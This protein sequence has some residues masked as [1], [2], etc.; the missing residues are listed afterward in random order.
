[1]DVRRALEIEPGSAAAWNSLGLILHLTGREEAAL[2][3]FTRACD[4]DARFGEAWMNRGFILQVLG[5]QIDAIPCFERAIEGGL[6]TPQVRFFLGNAFAAEGRHHEA[7]REFDLAV[8]AATGFA[9]AWNNRGSSL[10]QIS[11]FPE[12]AE[13]YARALALKERIVADLERK[14]GREAAANAL[15]AELAIALQAQ[16]RWRDAVACAGKSR[17]PALRFIASLLMPV[18]F[19]S[20]GMVV[21]ALEHLGTSV[22][23]LCEP[24]LRLDD[25][26]RQVGITAFHLPYFGT[27]ERPYQEAIARAYLHAVPGIETVPDPPSGAGRPRLGVLSGLLRNHSVYSMFGGLIERLDP[28]RFEVVFLQTAPGD[29]FTERIAA[30]AARHVRL[31]AN[32]EQARRQ[33]LA[34]RLDVL[35]YPEVGGD[36]LSYFLGFSRLAPVQCVTW[37]HPQTTGSPAMDYFISS[38]HLEREDGDREYS[39]KLVRMPHLNAW[40]SPPPPPPPRSPGQLG[41]PE[42]C[43]LYAYLQIANKLHPD[44]DRVLNEILTRDP[45][46]LLVLSE[47]LRPSFKAILARR[48]ETTAPRLLD[49]TVWLP[50]MPLDR[51]LRVLQL[52]DALLAPI[53]FGGGRS[54]FDALSAGVPVVT[55]RGPFL[56]SRITHAIY[57]EAGI[58][59]LTAESDEQYIELALRLARD[60]KWREQMRS[61]VR[62]KAPACFES[63]AAVRDLNEFFASIAPGA[64]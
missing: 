54:T 4:C 14:P 21:E 52:T 55:F 62:T 58:E 63:E 51:Y 6:A 45:E 29:G 5:R 42:G 20:S 41:L 7:L 47:P 57:K 34:E 36:P 31:S 56:K 39:E 1:A 33:V 9:D 17:E 49:R 25:P 23:S 60:R 30:R 27:S 46:G 10:E 28:E 38:E 8:A 15:R 32:L 64:S 44:F 2:D 18:V 26:L 37:G 12:A 22:D 53:Q 59:G 19:E 43:H 3:A 50:H 24:D 61:E 40:Y 11:M 35:F 48:W 16:G 13:S